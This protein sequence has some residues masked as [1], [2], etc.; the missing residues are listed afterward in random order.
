MAGF[1]IRLRHLKGAYIRQLEYHR[2]NNNNGL[3]C[4][5]NLIVYHFLVQNM[6]T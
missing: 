2:E 4:K 1:N 5:N 3:R 6:A